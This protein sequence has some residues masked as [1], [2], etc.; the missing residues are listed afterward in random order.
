MENEMPITYEFPMDNFPYHIEAHKIGDTVMLC[1][2]EKEEGSIWGKDY[3]VIAVKPDK[4]YIG[5]PGE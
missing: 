5:C 3:F 1:F 4:I 2:T